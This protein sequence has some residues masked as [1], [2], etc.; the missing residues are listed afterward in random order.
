MSWVLPLANGLTQ[1]HLPAVVP[2]G[3]SQGQKALP[4]K[5]SDELLKMFVSPGSC[6]V[7][8][9]P[10]GGLPCATGGRDGQILSESLPTQ[11]SI[12]LPRQLWPR[13]LAA[14]TDIIAR[15]NT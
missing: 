12:V 6:L 11:Q 9:A 8:P 13:R 3:V 7:S 5:R 1:Q 14:L 4:E 10:L 15:E 2:A